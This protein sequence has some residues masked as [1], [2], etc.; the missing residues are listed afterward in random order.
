MGEAEHPGQES[1]PSGGH[2]AVPSPR[3]IASL[4]LS[5][6]SLDNGDGRIGLF[7]GI[8]RTSR[9]PWVVVAG[10]VQAASQEAD[11][12]PAPPPRA[13]GPRGAGPHPRRAPPRGPSQRSSPALLA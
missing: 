4:V 8:P 11:S 10:E 2:G 5:P 12:P 13:K 9:D 3:G 7:S 1:P 6:F